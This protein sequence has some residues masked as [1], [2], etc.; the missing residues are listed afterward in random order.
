MVLCYTLVKGWKVHYLGS[1]V[2]PNKGTLFPTI[3][4]LIREPKKKKG[5]RLLLGNLVTGALLTRLGF[6]AIVY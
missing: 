1:P 3:R 2:A 4:F 5:K 6:E